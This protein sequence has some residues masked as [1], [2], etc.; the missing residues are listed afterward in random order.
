MCSKDKHSKVKQ[1]TC[2]G[3]EG[4]RCVGG[5]PRVVENVQDF[6]AGRAE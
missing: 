1:C 4:L 6:Q 5:C 2:H 3:N